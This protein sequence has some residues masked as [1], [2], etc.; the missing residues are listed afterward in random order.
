MALKLTS[1]IDH[2]LR[3]EAP[4]SPASPWRSWSASC[5]IASSIKLASNENPLGPF[6]HGRSKALHR[7]GASEVQPLSRRRLFCAAGVG[8][9]K[10]SRRRAGTAGVRLRSRR[11]PRASGED[12]PERRVTR[13]CSPW[14]SFAMYPIVV[15]G[16]GGHPGAGAAGLRTSRHDLCRHGARRSAR[17]RRSYS[18]ATPTTRPA[19]AS[20]STPFDRFVE[21]LP[22]SV[23]LA[24]W[25]RPTS[26]SC[27]APIFRRRRRVAGPS[28][29]NPGDAHL[30]EDLRA[31]R[32]AHRLRDRQ[33]PELVGYLER[34][35]HSLQRQ[36][37]GRGGRD[38][39]LSTTTEHVRAD[40]GIERPGHRLSG[41]RELTALGIEVLPKRCELHV[42]AQTGAD[43]TYEKLLREGVIVRPDAGLRPGRARPHYGGTARENERLVKTLRRV[44][45]GP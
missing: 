28:P 19:R 16:H 40:P 12:L 35:P 22:D 29:G 18:S 20:G 31:G 43:M 45:G 41:Q 9:R 13:S 1:S 34:A 11:N 32:A 44:A 6:A 10:R 37:A 27:G 3:A 33:T 7:C 42:G 8:S 25:T 14:P 17:R 15:Q 5:G 39:R 2:I 30:L 24:W 4:T 36:S 23:I 26:S 21:S 38:L